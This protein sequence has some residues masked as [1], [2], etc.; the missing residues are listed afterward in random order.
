MS[1]IYDTYVSPQVLPIEITAL[2]DLL[3]ERGFA[4]HAGWPP[5]NFPFATQPY[6]QPGLDY[7]DPA[8]NRDKFAEARPG[9]EDDA[10]RM[11]ALER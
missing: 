2:L 9:R 10:Q 7:Y 5:L 6:N 4:Y 3:H 8:V 1:V 11:L